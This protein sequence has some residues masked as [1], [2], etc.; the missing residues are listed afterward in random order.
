MRSSSRFSGELE[1]YLQ[2]LARKG[3][4]RGPDL[5]PIVK[6]WVEERLAEAGA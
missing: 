4:L 5:K 2:G 3:G 6:A 1:V